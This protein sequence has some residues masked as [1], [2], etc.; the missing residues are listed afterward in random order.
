VIPIVAATIVTRG[1]ISSTGDEITVGCFV[2]DTDGKW[3]SPAGLSETKL[4]LTLPP[5]SRPF[6]PL[7]ERSWSKAV[8]LTSGA[9]TRYF[10]EDRMSLPSHTPYTLVRLP[11]ISWQ[12]RL[13]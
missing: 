7:F 3:D 2:R 4:S 8:S 11:K 1:G 9:L 5:I 6:E 10:R 13:R 12:R